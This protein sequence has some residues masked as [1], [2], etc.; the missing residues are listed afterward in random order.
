MSDDKIRISWEDVNNP[1]VDARLK[2]QQVL[3]RAQQHYGQ[4]GGPPSASAA[5]QPLAL[6]SQ[7]KL[8]FHG[9]FAAAVFGCLGGVAGWALG[10]FAWWKMPSPLE[11]FRE[12]GLVVNYIKEQQEHG[13][14]SENDA[15]AALERLEARCASNPYVQ[16]FMDQ[17]R[18]ETDKQ[19]AF[20]SLA[21]KDESREKLLQM[22]WFSVIAIAIGIATSIAE[23]VV[24]GNL[25]SVALNAMAG[26]LLG[27]I[28]GIVVSLFANT[29]YNT[30]GGGDGS[31]GIGQ[32]I[33]ARAIGWGVLGLFLAIAP[34]I[35]LRSWKRSWIGLAGGLVGGLLGGVMFDPITLI[36]GSVVLSRFCGIVAIG[37]VTA[38]STG[39]I[40]QVAKTG[41]LRVTAGL[42][43]GKQFVLYRN[44][45]FVGSS[46]QCEI[47][48]FKD[49]QIAP[50]HAALHQVRGGYEIED[51]CSASGMFVNG[52]AVRRTRLRAGDQIQ[53]GA[54]RLEYQ[55][56][57]SGNT[58]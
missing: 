34:G 10:E 33:I 39:V 40:E 56:K 28:G 23:P 52:Q 30:L 31:I 41:W 4:P 29:L 32:Q 57:T 8:L 18:S 7:R 58:S 42:I 24:S 15:Q 17:S 22:I 49:P 53:I 25:R 35:V 44:P 1:A 14:L 3:Q 46:P 47:Y 50:R 11:E 20:K 21:E 2:L 45:T 38:V 48:L 5:S 37:T 6:V 43:A 26:A 55:E 51:L 9:V 19:S 36:T 16:L 27:M 12:I 13:N 54:T